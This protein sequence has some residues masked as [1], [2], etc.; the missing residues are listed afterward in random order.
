MASEKKGFSVHKVFYE[1]T[2]AAYV[3]ALMRMKCK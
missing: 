3:A 2:L 1:D